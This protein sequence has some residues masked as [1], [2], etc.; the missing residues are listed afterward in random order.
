VTVRTRF[1]PSPTGYLH[2]GGARTALFS[3]LYARQNG[4]K[5]V[6][7]IEDTDAE[8]STDE[9]TEAILDGMEWLGLAHDEGPFFQSKRGDIYKADIEKLE[10]SGHLYRCY[11]T[12]EELQARREAARI[13]GLS[14][15][16]DGRCR[17]RTET[18]DNGETPY[19]LRFRVPDGSVIFKD[20]I[21]GSIKIQN[22]EIED[23]VLLRSDG[24]PTYNFCVVV[25]DSTMQISHVIRGDDHISNTAK[26]ILI[27]DALG[28]DLPVFAHLPMILGSDKARLSKRHG[29]TSVIAYKAEGYLP[30]ALVNYLARL[31]WSHG[32]QEIFS[33]EELVKLFSFDNVGKAAG[34]FNPEKLL[35]L[36]AHYIKESTD[37]ALALLLVP[38]LAELGVE[39]AEE[40]ARLET[41]VSTLKERAKTLKDMAASAEF[42]F[43]SSV[44]YEEKPRK[45]FLKAEKLPI[46]KELLAKLGSLDAFSVN[47]IETI[48]NALMEKTDL[49][50]GKIAQ[51]VRVALTGGTVSPGIFETIEAMG[52][53]MVM[54][55][56][57]AA[58]EYIE[59]APDEA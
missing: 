49:K 26:Q 31:G 3:W 37:S 18:S 59:N 45:K 5:F 17:T 39:N 20:L 14:P 35:W 47:E 34:V 27:Y 54:S 33:M 10:A 51:P 19:A 4:G 38:F 24:S 36:N 21:K 1:A 2:I 23:M 28:Y 13:K 56:L 48:F 30:H 55:R 32:D 7:R 57:S 25:D 11:C 53:K 15:K 6:L 52:S 44:E 22:S 40:D 46:F 8:R 16:Y 42:Y 50:L 43:L 9:S 12:T 41:I 58:I 29:A